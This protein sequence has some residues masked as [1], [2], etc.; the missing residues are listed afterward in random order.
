[1]DPS[2]SRN[3]PS[4]RNTHK[5]DK[6]TNTQKS[7][8]SSNTHNAATLA[9]K[10]PGAFAF[11]LARNRLFWSNRVQTVNKVT[12]V[13]KPA[14]VGTGS[15]NKKPSVTQ[16]TQSDYTQTEKRKKPRKS[17][18]SVLHTTVNTSR[19]TLVPMGKQRPD[20]RNTL[21]QIQYNVV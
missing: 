19:E 20:P 3:A 4:R 15:T 8:K 2:S 17:T 7:H 14:A 21:H 11:L 16:A 5:S 13:S 18:R 12:K 1:M 9:V 6:S 10:E